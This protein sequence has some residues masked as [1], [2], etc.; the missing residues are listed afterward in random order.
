M[1]DY[2]DFNDYEVMYLVEEGSEDAENIIIDKYT[3]LIKSMASSYLKQFSRYG[4]EIDDLVQEGYIGLYNAIKGYH[5]SKNTLFYTY[6]IISIR[7]KML[8]FLKRHTSQKNFAN[9]DCISLSQDISDDN[10]APL[11]SLIE[12][13][14]AM[15]PAEMFENKEL[16]NQVKRFMYSLDFPLSLIFEL[17]FNGFSAK[18]IS[19]LL[20]CPLKK[21]INDMF[22]IRKSSNQFFGH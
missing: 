4:I 6:A 3:P 16:E 11:F 14:K 13:K 9:V 10:N 21:I 19:T 7:S 22:K 8:N 2:K 20:D 17:K 18:D 12:D 5:A 15:L 1:K